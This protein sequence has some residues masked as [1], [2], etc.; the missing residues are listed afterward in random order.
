MVN[1]SYNKQEAHSKKLS[2]Q[3]KIRHHP[4]FV[5]RSL[6]RYLSLL[7]FY[8]DLSIVIVFASWIDS[9]I[10]VFIWLIHLF[11]DN[12]SL[13]LEIPNFRTQLLCL[14]YSWLLLDA[15][16]KYF[17]IRWSMFSCN[18]H[19]FLFHRKPIGLFSSTTIPLNQFLSGIVHSEA[20]IRYRTTI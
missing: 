7:S 4:L 3:F 14:P 6:I 10:V 1:F 16:P 8:F 12:L 20:M 18:R 19:S 11:F 17:V 13:N 9:S 15:C 2:K 5:K